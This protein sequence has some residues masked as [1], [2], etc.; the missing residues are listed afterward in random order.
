V[1]LG[2]IL[3]AHGVTLA[4]HFLH[5]RAK[6]SGTSSY[7]SEQPGAVGPAMASRQQL[8]ITLP[9]PTLECRNFVTGGFAEVLAPWTRSPGSGLAFGLSVKKERLH[10]VEILSYDSFFR[11]FQ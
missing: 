1:P 6:T 7:L 3:R 4:Y 2:W 10:I 8:F 11:A 9:V 5:T